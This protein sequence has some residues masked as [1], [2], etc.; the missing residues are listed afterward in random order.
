M[1]SK[2]SAL[3]IGII[4]EKPV[5]PYE[6][7][8]MLDYIN[9]KNWFSMG[10]SSVYAVIK[11]LQ[12]KQ[13]IC[14]TNIKEG[15]MPEKTIYSLTPT[16]R[17]ELATTIEA[18]LGNVDLDYVKFNIALIFL[19]HLP[20]LRAMELIQL[21][22]KELTFMRKRQLEQLKKLQDIQ[23]LGLQ[24]IKST[25]NITEAHIKSSEELLQ[26]IENDSAWN[27]FLVAD[28]AIKFTCRSQRKNP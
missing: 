11:N 17:N 27:H 25:L 6:I 20:K 3:I 23:M 28:S 21:R 18:F 26:I 9:I 24:A 7:T 12:E 15:N 8:K 13:F 2:S 1:L 22:L 4:A 16:G 5:N 10:V 14:G 19:C